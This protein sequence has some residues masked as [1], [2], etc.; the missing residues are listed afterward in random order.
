MAAENMK[1]GTGS[2]I[3]VIDLSDA[4]SELKCIVGREIMDGVLKE[5]FNKFCVGK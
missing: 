4:L 5:I 3:V 1:A 2:E